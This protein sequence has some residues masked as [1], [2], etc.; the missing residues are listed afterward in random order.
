MSIITLEE[1]KKMV[2]LNVSDYDIQISELIP[3]IE[4]DILAIRNRPWD[5]DSNYN[6]IHPY[7]I[8]MIAAEMISFK[9]NTLKG[10]FGLSSEHVGEYSVS[11]SNDLFM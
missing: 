9:I 2:N 10:S 1:Y 4:E 5:L 11:Y 6:P 7:N 8:K 3:I